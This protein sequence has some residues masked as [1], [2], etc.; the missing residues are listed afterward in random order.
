MKLSKTTLGNRV[1]L[2]NS[3][4]VPGGSNVPDNFLL[5]VFFKTS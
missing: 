2:G 3:S 1:F 5:G 4:Y